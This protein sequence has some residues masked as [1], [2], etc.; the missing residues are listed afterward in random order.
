M[1]QLSNVR[2]ALQVTTLK[3]FVAADPQVFYQ[4]RH[5]NGAGFAATTHVRQY[6]RGDSLSGDQDDFSGSLA[7][8]ETLVNLGGFIERVLRDFDL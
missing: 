4:A 2:A 7:P 6:G 8:F 5:V 1:R 3:A